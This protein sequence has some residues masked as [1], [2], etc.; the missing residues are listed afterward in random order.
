MLVRMRGWF[1]GL[2]LAGT[3]CGPS[4]PQHTGYPE[5]KT[6]P[7]TAAKEITL[8]DRLEGEGKG[9]LN[10]ANRARAR[11]FSIDLPYDGELA[12]V[13]TFDADNAGADIGVEIL[14]EG[15]NVRAQGTNDDDEGRPKKVR[16]AKD[17]NKGKV[18]V[19]VYVLGK[20]DSLDFRV[21]AQLKP[22]LRDVAPAGFPGNIPNTPMIAAVPATDDAPRR[23]GGKTPPKP[24]EPKPVPVV[25]DTE[26]GSVKARVLEYSESGDRVK[27]TINR[28]SD[29]GIE[30][31]WTGYVIDSATKRRL[32]GSDFTVNVVK[33]QECEG[34]AKISLSQAQAHRQ[35]VLK[36][37]K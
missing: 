8:N 31:G 28:G 27:L 36:P 34:T 18:Y 10:Y 30:K 11:W 33:P 2:A 19:H 23:G 12:L 7:W 22:I 9:E 1:L 32:S 20:K 5:G 26:V 35:V 15:F 24:P 25:E 6:Q 17:L 16:S 4:I 37:A 3:A 13:T 29:N 14:D 21:R